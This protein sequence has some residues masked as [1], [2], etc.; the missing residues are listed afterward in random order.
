M[1]KKI[2][3]IICIIAILCALAS[4]DFI[5]DL[6]P[7]TKHFDELEINFEATDHTASIVESKDYVF[8]AATD[9]IYRKD[10]NRGDLCTR[11]VKGAT[12]ALQVFDETLYYLD[13]KR[14]KL[15]AVEFNSKNKRTIYS[16]GEEVFFKGLPEYKVL[17]NGV[18]FADED[19]SVFYDATKG[20]AK[21]IIP[22]RH[23][24]VIKFDVVDNEFY[25]I[26]SIRNTEQIQKTSLSEYDPKSVLP[27]VVTNEVV[28]DFA[29]G[30]DNLYYVTKCSFEGLL[31]RFGIHKLDLATLEVKDIDN[32]NGVY[33]I[34]A[35]D[36]DLYY[37]EDCNQIMQFRALTETKY[38]F[39]YVKNYDSGEMVHST[40]PQIGFYYKT[41]KYYDSNYMFLEEDITSVS[42]D[43]FYVDGTKDLDYTGDKYKYNNVK[44]YPISNFEEA[45]K[46]GKE[47]YNQQNS[48]HILKVVHW[49]APDN[50]WL[51]MY[52]YRDCVLDEIAGCV[53]FDGGGHIII[54]G[55]TGEI[56]AEEHYG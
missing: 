26:P 53:V 17:K 28:T 12:I 3:T 23:S 46:L 49:Y 34:V 36:Q 30:G 20:K 55:D 25:Y 33:S 38:N 54:D 27:I 42:R 31:S 44:T 8:Y 13:A 29:I 50:H 1:I 32:T 41:D 4:V 48:N 6:T 45:E 40:Y 15:C 9:G 11:I 21:Q 10:K 16:L 51:L 52:R 37:L 35:V 47:I 22:G 43:V 14:T 18:V 5:K 39:G 7:V 19:C 56:V 24:G 2:I